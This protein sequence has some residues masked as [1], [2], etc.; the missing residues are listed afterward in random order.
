MDIFQSTYK[1]RTRSVIFMQSFI[2]H[3][4]S[5]LNQHNCKAHATIIEEKIGGTTPEEILNAYFIRVAKL[6]E[7]NL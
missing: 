5:K 3:R 6:K 1:I 7:R 2:T 4:A